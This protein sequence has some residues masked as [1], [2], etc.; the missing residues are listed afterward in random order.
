MEPNYEKYSLDELYDALSHIDKAAYP[1]RAKQI[2]DNIKKRQQ[3][4]S[5]ALVSSATEQ[6]LDSP[7]PYQDE[8]HASNWVAKYW[9]GQFS[10][11]I[12]Y[13]LV[14]IAINLFILAFGAVI[15]NRIEQA[16]SRLSLGLLMLSLYAVILPLITWQTVGIYRSANRHPYRGGSIFW[17]NAAKAITIISAL[18]YIINILTTGIPIVKESFSLIT[19]HQEYPETQ[20]RLLNNG[21]ELELFGGIEVGSE[22]Q[23]EAQLEAHPNVKLL[24]LHSIGGRMLGAIRMAAIVKQRKLDT[25][26]KE[27]CASACTVVYLA[28]E[29][30]LIGENGE[31]AFHAAGMGGTSMHNNET[32]G[33]SLKTEY[34][35]AGVPNWFLKKVLATPNDDLWI[36]DHNK[37]RKAKIITQVV[38]SAEYGFSG[39][40]GNENITEEAIEQGLL[41]HNYMKAMKE[42]DPETYQKVIAINRQVMTEGGTINSVSVAINQLL[43]TR[44]NHYL[45][46]ASNE[47]V[48]YYWQTIITQME[49]LRANSPLACASYAFPSDIPLQH[50]YG[51]EGTLPS[52]LIEQELDAMGDLIGSFSPN[53]TLLSIEDKE[54][55]ILQVVE[56]LKQEN[57]SYV[58]VIQ[59][60]ADY[61]SD[62]DTLC[63]ASITL[64]KQFVAFTPEIS[65]ALLRSINAH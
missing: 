27:R 32:L 52:A 12:S 7:S 9:K 23:L 55:Y 56:S 60:P 24:H 34:I 22:K 39:F 19:Q 6:Q 64:N 48:L 29:N 36:P 49:A 35:N 33:S 43:Q 8:K 61:L 28:G 16:D 54:D 38:N 3:R 41:T 31:L 5:S 10:L 57:G 58:K 50:H 46:H 15:E 65:G 62:P 59:A 42:F 14:G 51:N 4:G 21:T 20:F 17:A 13:W 40:G 18:G 1:E 53:P 45:A 37:L 44:I 47:A 30:R 63:L 2:Q 26:V 25:Y 11:P